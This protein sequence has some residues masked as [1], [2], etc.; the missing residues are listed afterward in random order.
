MVAAV[1]QGAGME[2][3]H[4]DDD[5]EVICEILDISISDVDSLGAT[6]SASSEVEPAR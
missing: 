1:A 3:L 4:D 6:E 5:F 2:I